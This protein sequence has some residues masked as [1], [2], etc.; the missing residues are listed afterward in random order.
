MQEFVNFL[1]NRTFHKH[2]LLAIGG[3]IIFLLI[4]FLALRVY[5]RH[6]QALSVPDFTG[7][8]LE[9]VSKIVDQKNLRYEIIDSV[10]TPGAQPGTVVAQSPSPDTKVKENRVIFL[11]INAFNPEKIEMPNVVDVSLQQAEAILQTNGLRVGYKHYVPHQA[12]DYVIRQI[13]HHHDIAPGSKVTK[14]SSIDLVLGLGR[15]NVDVDVPD[16][17]G[18]TRTEAEGTLSIKYLNFGAVIYDNSVETK[19]DSLRAVI[20]KQLPANGS[21]INTGSTVDVWLTVKN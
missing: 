19:Q 14:G 11:T 1:K 20:W 10:F 4:V 6:G 8:T 17:K 3:L 2:L 15:I 16:L 18:L 13:Y 7:A 5:T 12:K 21:S 9:E